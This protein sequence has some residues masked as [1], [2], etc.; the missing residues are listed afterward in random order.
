MT[1]K[2]YIALDI[3]GVQSMPAFAGEIFSITRN[4]FGKPMRDPKYQF[5]RK[6]WFIADLFNKGYHM[7]EVREWCTEQ[8]G[9][10]SENPDAWSRWIN[11]TNSLF[12][13]RDEKD[14]VLFVLRWGS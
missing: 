1:L 5:S 14:Y 13:F 11:N 8:F 7:S 10:K 4:R 3:I 2:Q 9:L 6:D 12:R